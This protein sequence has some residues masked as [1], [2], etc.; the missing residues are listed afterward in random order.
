VWVCGEQSIL[1]ADP[2]YVIGYTS[3][4][5]WTIKYSKTIA[6]A[7]WGPWTDLDILDSNIIV[8]GRRSATKGWAWL[9]TDAGA[10]WTEYLDGAEP[11]PGWYDC[12]ACAFRLEP[13]DPTPDPGGGEASGTG[14]TMPGGGSLMAGGD[15]DQLEGTQDGD[16]EMSAD[17]MYV[18]GGTL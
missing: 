16:L 6:A 18:I 7:S 3:G 15:A 4:A 8:S 1:A 5:S 14:R 17:D 10:S 11:A 2:N 12:G 9:S 13:D